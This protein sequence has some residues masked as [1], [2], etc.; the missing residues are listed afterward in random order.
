[1]ERKV[2][3]QK[4]TVQNRLRN[5]VFYQ[6]NHITTVV[7]QINNSFRSAFVLN[8]DVKESQWVYED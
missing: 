1:M 5:V 7:I 2:I 8:S 3:R 6:N 4:I